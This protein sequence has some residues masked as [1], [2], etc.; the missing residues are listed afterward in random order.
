MPIETEGIVFPAPLQVEVRK[1]TLP[2]IGPHDVGVRTVY[3]GVSLGT[4]GHALRGSYNLGGKGKMATRVAEVYPYATGYQKSGIVDKVGSEV[5]RLKVGDRVALWFTKILDPDLVGHSWPGHSGYSVQDENEVYPL[6]DSVDL[7]EASLFVL[8]GV[9]MHGNRLANVGQGDTV[10]I[11]GQGMIGQMSAQCARLRG[12]RV[13]SCDLLAKRVAAS[14]RYSADVAVDGSRED[15]AAVVRAE[16][17]GGADVVTDTTGRAVMF[18]ACLNLVRRE[19]KIILQGYY[20]DPIIIDFH[21]AHA[22]R[23]AVF[24][25]ESTEPAEDIVAMLATR[26][27]QIKPLITHRLSYREAPD[28]YRAVLEQPDDILG[29]VFSW[30]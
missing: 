21:P 11:F 20:P 9:G 19:G 16:K 14:A 12:A 25:P 6:A 5:S 10:A 1:L 18:N 7:E 8:A 30:E 17:P 15:F 13:L 2:D 24:F 3:S 23:I 4:E 22:K 27:L 28:A 29:M 26:K